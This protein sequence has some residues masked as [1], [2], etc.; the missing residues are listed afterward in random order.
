MCKTDSAEMEVWAG[1]GT[2]LRVETHTF[3]PAWSSLMPEVGRRTE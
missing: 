1:H 2:V 3:S